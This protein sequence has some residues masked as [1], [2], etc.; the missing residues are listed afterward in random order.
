M[1]SAP[2]VTIGLPTYNRA[3]EVERGIESA[4]AQDYCNLELV[5][6]DNCSTDHTQLVCERF[7]AQDNRVRYIRQPTNRGP[8]ANFLEVLRLAR[9]EFFMWLGDDDWLDS[10]YVSQCAQKLIENPDY[11]LVCGVAQYYQDKQFLLEGETMVLLQD[12]AEERVLIFYGEV[13]HNGTFY[14][15]MRLR[16][17]HLA[18]LQN[19][20]GSDWI[21]IA[22][23]AFMGKID[24]VKGT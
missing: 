5:I 9:G 10:S 2:L 16:Q 23:I 20:L 22:A 18:S 3:S 11:S 15:I 8:K 1:N 19:V 6:S 7:C 12:R 14:G 24:I 21:L 4:L 13:V 17:L